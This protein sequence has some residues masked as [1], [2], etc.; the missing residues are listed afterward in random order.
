MKPPVFTQVITL[1]AL[2]FCQSVGAEPTWTLTLDLPEKKLEVDLSKYTPI[3][4]LESNSQDCTLQEIMVEVL[5]TSGINAQAFGMYTTGDPQMAVRMPAKICL[6]FTPKSMGFVT[7]LRGFI[8]EQFGEEDNFFGGSTGKVK[9]KWT[10]SFTH[11]NGHRYACISFNLHDYGKVKT[12]LNQLA[13]LAALSESDK[14]VF[15][16]AYEQI[17]VCATKK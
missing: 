15:S 4:L 3:L 9:Y 13:E 1:S 2:L 12:V 10:N 11:D 8:K 17:E 14:A 6:N 7:E 5:P 16:K